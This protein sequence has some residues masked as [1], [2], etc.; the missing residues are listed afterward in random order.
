MTRKLIGTLMVA[1]GMGLG[2]WIGSAER[3]PIDRE[4]APTRLEVDLSERKMYLYHDE[5]VVNSYDV[6]VGE[7]EHPTPSGNFQIDRIEWNPDWVPPNSEWAEDEERK[8]PDDPDN[9]MVGAKLFFKYPD[10]Y[11]HG[12]NAQHTLGTAASHGCV[13]MDPERVKDLAEWVQNHGGKKRSDAWYEEAK[14]NDQDA[15]VI[16]LPDAIPLEI[17]A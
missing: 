15:E 2:A 4:L 7:P 8:E 12:T 17:R 5:R 11:I 9:P 13:R 14:Q 10:Y 16:S 6:A 3:S 1:G